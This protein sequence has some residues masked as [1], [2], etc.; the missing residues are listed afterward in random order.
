MP[1]T[2][3]LLSIYFAL[4]LLTLTLLFSLSRRLFLRKFCNFSQLILTSRS[5]S[6]LGFAVC[7]GTFFGPEALKRGTPLI[8]RGAPQ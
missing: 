7:L 4:L 2:L 6:G 3:T 8:L 5:C 1:L